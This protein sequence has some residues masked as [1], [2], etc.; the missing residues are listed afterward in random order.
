MAEH[1]SDKQPCAALY[2]MRVL[3]YELEDSRQ[4]LARAQGELE[5]LR[6]R[7]AAVRT[8]RDEGDLRWGRLGGRARMRVVCV[9][10]CS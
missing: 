3:Q 10:A 2:L 6:Q 9:C 5:A 8:E 4:A 7:L 1:H